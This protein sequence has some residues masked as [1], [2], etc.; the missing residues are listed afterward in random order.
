MG[1]LVS[2]V[3]ILLIVLSTRIFYFIKYFP[4]DSKWV[5]WIILNYN[6]EVSGI[7]LLIYLVGG[8]RK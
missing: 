6:Y 3:T 8:Q 4:I 7:V 5:F 2:T 1:T